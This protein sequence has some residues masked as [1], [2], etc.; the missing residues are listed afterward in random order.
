MALRYEKKERVAYITLNRPEAL[1]A[2]DPEQVKEFSDALL[3]MRDDD[4]IWVGI[5]TGAGERA[6]C[7]GADIKRLLPLMQGEWA[8]PGKMP[9]NVMRGLALYKPL[10][11]AVNGLALGGGL[12]VAL[13]C[14]IRVAAENAAFGLPEV[15]LGLIAGWGGCSRLPRLIPLAKAAEIM[16]TGEP[17]PAAEAYRIG[18]VNEVVPL[19]DLLPTAER[20]AARIC[21]PGPLAVRA[22]KEIMLKTQ[23]MTLDESLKLE[24]ERIQQLFRS[25]DAQ[26]GMA[27]FVEKRKA[28]FQSK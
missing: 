10:I 11:A 5:I 27:A 14:D 7:A 9:P 26:E 17:M 16:L 25:H 28:Q 19:K 13:A 24:W 6:F 3:D 15:R 20:W 8:Q 1:N 23:N 22:A 2:F 21:I 12:E 18:L 4:N